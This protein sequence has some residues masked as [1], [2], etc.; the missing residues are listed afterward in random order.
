MGGMWHA[1]T[2]V[3]EKGETA[4][5]PSATGDEAELGLHVARLRRV[6]VSVPEDLK[7]ALGGASES[8][9]T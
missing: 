3:D 8:W 7:Y 1:L 5:D 9:Y 6:V 4:F 2:C